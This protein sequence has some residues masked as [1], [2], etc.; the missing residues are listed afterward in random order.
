MH[1]KQ[2]RIENCNQLLQAYKEGKL[3]YSRMP[4][5]AHPTFE[6][7]EQRLAFFTLP[8]SLNYQRDSYKLW[9]AATQTFLDKETTDVFDV[10]K[11]T[12]MNEEVLREKLLKHKVALQPNKHIHTWKIISSTIA[13]EWGSMEKMVKEMH[14]DYLQF[15]QTIQHTSKKGFPYL[16][17][18]KIFNYWCFIM[19]QYGKIKLQNADLIEIAPDTHITK[20]SVKLGIITAEEAERLSKDQISLRWRDSLKDSGITPIEMHPPLWFW[21]RNNFLYELK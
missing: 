11:V 7:E 10:Q 2:K 8:M 16:S 9:E 17:G 5:D 4:E 14:A 19:Q 21:S 13:K 15:R 3:G 12:K 20:C 6:N 18:P 1:P